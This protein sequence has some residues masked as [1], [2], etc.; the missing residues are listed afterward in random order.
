M[1][2]LPGLQRDVVLAPFTTY[3]IG[4][5]ADMFVEVTSS[6]E[7]V[8][9]VLTARNTGV[10]YFILGT[11][12]NILVSDA[13]V[14]GLVIH[15]RAA[16]IDIDIP[17]GLITA[18]SGATLHEV[19]TAAAE[20]DLG[21][22]E[23][24]TFVPSSVGGAVRQNFHFVRVDAAHYA[25]TGEIRAGETQ[26]L[27][28]R[29]VRG[30]ILD[31]AG[32]IHQVDRDWFEFDYDYSVML[33]NSVV[34]LEAVIR[35]QPRP[36]AEIEQQIAASAAWR[37][38][39]QPILDEFPSSGSVFINIPGVGAGRLI[40]QAGLKGRTIG[41]AQV[42]PKHANYLVNLG[43]ATAADVRALI[44]LVQ[45]EVEAKTGYRLETEIGFVGDWS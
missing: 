42:S 21:D 39:K 38:L 13:G 1:L 22:I 27:A 2:E 44:D 26:Y 30:V 33:H 14:R 19:I 16:H 15:N 31:E 10:P 41:R 17:N 8:Q 37:H 36:R 40:D 3:R 32:E 45:R 11:G 34:L 20:V 18:E 23:Y 6:A 43:G 35:V 25:A 4:G 28:D 29:V 7:L 5:P 12:A 24:F 9:A